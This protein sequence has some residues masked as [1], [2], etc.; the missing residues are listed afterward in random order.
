[1]P[2]APFIITDL[3]LAGYMRNHTAAAA[4]D[5]SLKQEL[6]GSNCHQQQQVGRRIHNFVAHS[7]AERHVQKRYN[8]NGLI[9]RQHFD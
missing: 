1:M 9:K 8:I 2:N 4:V 6:S 7:F 5:R 3:M